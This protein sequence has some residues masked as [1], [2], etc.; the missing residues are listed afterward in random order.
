[1]KDAVNSCVCLDKFV[2]GSMY[3]LKGVVSE[4]IRT[5]KYPPKHH[6]DLSPHLPKG[7]ILVFSSTRGLTT[8][9]FA[10][11]DVMYPS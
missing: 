11:S 4:I 5:P 6:P 8:Q 10:V 1:M 7:L 2:M 3:E 9:L